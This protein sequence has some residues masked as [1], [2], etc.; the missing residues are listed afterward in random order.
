[1]DPK[2]NPYPKLVKSFKGAYPFKIGTTSFIYPDNYLPNVTLLG[3]FLDEI[4]LLLFESTGIDSI[5]T[6]T[7]IRDLYDLSK[8]MD[9]TYNVHLPMDIS[10]SDPDPTRQQQ[11]TDVLAKIIDR[12]SPLCPST[13]TLHIPFS[14][15][16]YASDNVAKWQERVRRNLEKILAAGIQGNSISIETLGYPFDIVASL[17]ADLN[18]SICMDLGHLMVNGFDIQREFIKY[19]DNISIIHL[20]GVENGRDH[21][22]LDRLPQNFMSQILQILKKFKRSLS[23]EVFGYNDL[24]A[25][26]VFL[27]MCW[28]NMVAEKR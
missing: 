22:S 4:E 12:I 20:H 23:L 21:L 26:L 7:L 27:E 16:S 24:S 15:E 8:A 18:L 11:A 3:P 2:T 28:Q 19:F 13:H 5:L 9:L 14:E 25:S 1:M 17:V 6:N 10:I